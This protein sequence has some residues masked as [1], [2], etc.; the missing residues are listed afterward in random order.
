MTEA[1]FVYAIMNSQFKG[2]EQQSKEVTKKLIERIDRYTDYLKQRAFLFQKSFGFNL[3][4]KLRHT[5]LT[6]F[7]LFFNIEKE[8]WE[9]DYEFSYSASSLILF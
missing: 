3:L 7:E 4:D 9:T 1:I 8:C 2:N 5:G 6:I